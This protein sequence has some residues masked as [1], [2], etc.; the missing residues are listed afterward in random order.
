MVSKYPGKLFTFLSSLRVCKRG[1]TDDGL[2]CFLEG[3]RLYHR[4][5]FPTTDIRLSLCAELL[6][7]AIATR[8][9]QHEMRRLLVLDPLSTPPYDK[10]RL[11]DRYL[12]LFREWVRCLRLPKNDQRHASDGRY[13]G[14]YYYTEAPHQPY[15]K[16][17]L[18]S[19]A[20]K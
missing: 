20:L 4:R 12:R 7:Y 18:F 16:M 1:L 17:L 5:R 11:H 14:R 15:T 10:S 8:R 9:L 19:D 3:R 2:T 6:C 13:R